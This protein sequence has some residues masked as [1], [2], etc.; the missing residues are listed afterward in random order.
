MRA[1]P[2]P[3]P[4]PLRAHARD[5]SF[6]PSATSSIRQPIPVGPG[7]AP[8][9]APAHVGGASRNAV[10]G[11]SVQPGKV[12]PPPL[13]DETL[14]R[15]RLLDWLDVKVHNRVV[16][17]IADAGYGKTTLLADFTRRTRLRVLWYR[18]DI[19]D[20]NW[21]SFLSHLVAAG[22][23]QDPEFAP[24]TNALLQDTGP[25]GA[26][27]DDALEAF[28][29]ELPAIA[30][31][32]AVLILDDF[33]VSD[34][35]ADIG[36]I[37]REIVS[38]APERLTI[39]ISSRRMPT[40]PVARLR[41]LGEVAELRTEDLRFSA[42]E[43]ETLFTQTYGR[44]LEPDV[45]ADL[46]RRTDGWAASLA[47]VKTA[48]R[49]RSAAETRAFIRGLS[50]AQSELYDYLAEEVVGDLPA[51]HQTF[52]MR[53]SI[54]QSVDP[55]AAEVASG[56]DAAKVA[57]LIAAS[58]RIGLLSRRQ[59]N[60]RPGHTYHPL[61]RE[62]LE[63]RLV[64]EA[65]PGAVYS[66]HRSVARWAEG[67]DWRTACF[68][69]GAA[70]DAKGVHRVLEDSIESIVGTGEVAH[71]AGYLSRFPPAGDSA[72]FEIIWSRVAEIDVDVPAALAHA[73]RAVE[74]SPDSDASISN[75]LATLFLAGDLREAP[76]LADRL[77]TGA[78]SSTL[79][80][81]GTATWH[82]LR[83]SLEGDLNNAVQAITEVTDESRALG[84]AHYEGVGLLNRSHA[85]RA[86]GDAHQA[87]RDAV[88]AH[89]TLVRGS[90]GAIAMSAQLSKAWALAHLGELETARTELAD[91]FDRCTTATRPEW[92]VEAAILE[93]HYGDEGIAQSLCDEAD[94]LE[95]NPAVKAQMTLTEVE[96]AL[97]SSRPI[98]ARALLPPFPPD[99]P[100]QEA[101]HLARY[102]SISARLALALGDPH[103]E[104][105]IAE[106]LAFA[107]RQSAGLW[108][109]YSA[110]LLAVARRDSA[111][112]RRII[113]ADRTPL[114]LVAEVVIER[115]DSLDEGL[116][117]AVEGE[118]L[119]RP[120]RWRPSVRRAAANAAH[121]SR[122]AAARI[123][124]KIGG[125]QDVL[126]LR[127][128][129]RSRREKGPDAHLGRGLA[130]RLATRV[131]VEDQGRVEVCFGEKSISGTSI[132][133]KVLALLCYLLSR[134]KFSA[135]RDEVVDALW[136]NLE[137][138][139]AANSL[140]QT[141]Y[142]LRRVFEPAYKED[143]SAGYVNHD[144]DILWLDGELISSRTNRCR[145]L[146]DALSATPTPAEV[147]QLSNMY[148]G[149]F[150]LDFAYEEWAVP[151]REGLHVAYLQV[152]EG[153]V[154]RDMDSGHY[155]RAI[156]L[157]RRALDVDPD[158]ESLQVS[159]LRLYRNTGA[160]SAAA[161]QYAR[162]AA[163]LRSELGIEAPPLAAL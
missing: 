35:V 50:G 119:A 95:L 46:S 52:L 27:R 156:R 121:P 38:R 148:L 53:T 109:G 149:R 145:A 66:L 132:R 91:A 127:E 10:S 42:D 76:A 34:D 28:M 136:P 79:R 70:D 102:M 162:Y 61:V 58:E 1:M 86:R 105:D 32:G 158:I 128:V 113:L 100:T 99:I 20:R 97:R 123:L 118:A 41:A 51:D 16:L 153:A 24:R 64:R 144:S 68:H 159:L 84:L 44:E 140:N 122:L 150:A 49:D 93:T 72:G 87:L 71:A 55:D 6:Q 57:A 18:M 12:Q 30:T 151:Y 11:Y 3:E 139:V 143:T 126:L 137:P 75:L 157:A 74:L 130:R 62:F 89:A 125:P 67:R 45:L 63:A 39:V 54:L 78:R 112:L 2:H 163:Y 21:V 73:H 116:L 134:P 129:A 160:H 33:H 65:P 29:R 96:L 155:D 43:T 36:H 88:D 98:D 48:L 104:S 77:A 135:T 69:F 124:D 13:R 117:P 59:G 85:H 81:V 94:S 22:R 60:V 115:L 7:R 37:A 103:A 40:L 108:V 101:G 17:V 92:L 106:A 83:T 111:G 5:R 15:H 142:F 114:S 110:A 90:S 146:L 26:T 25:G 9:A 19:D 31:D 82:V 133:R 23:V 8:I 152:I 56:F 80:Q 141:V 14:A 161:E 154:N 131:V 138:T 120:D 4:L 47:L 107:R 147:D